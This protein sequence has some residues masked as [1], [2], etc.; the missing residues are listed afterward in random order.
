M[1]PNPY[2]QVILFGDSLIQHCTDSIDGFV[3]QSA[4]QAHCNRRL[5]IIN[6]GFSGY[7]TSQCLHI[8][9]DIIPPVSCTKVDYFLIL[10]GANDACIPGTTGQTVKLPQFK[11]N[12][13]DIISSPA[14]RAHNPTILLCTP[15]P[16]D[17]IHITELDLAYGWKSATRTSENTAAYAQVVRDIASAADDKVVLVDLYAALMEKA[18][19]MTPDWK[20]AGKVPIL[21]SLESGTRGGLEKLLPDGLH[22]SGEAYKV[23]ARVFTEEV[24]KEWSSEGGAEEDYEPPSWAFPSFWRA[25]WADESH[26]A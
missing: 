6:R 23:F 20:A 26:K 22:L 14:L 24:G 11:A 2:H 17:E 9:Q 1:A 16:V 19:S 21:G 18:V 12:L 3:F 7:N 10:L 5:D 15:P 8:L 25:A 13:E 4:I